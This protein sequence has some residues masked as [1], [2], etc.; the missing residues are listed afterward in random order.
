MSVTLIP[1]NA[2]R[3]KFKVKGAPAGLF[4]DKGELIIRKRI[5]A[6]D[7][8]VYGITMD[9]A[10]RRLPLRQK[11]SKKQRLATRRLAREGG[12]L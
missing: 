1:T 11:R 9:G 5:A 8:T 4:N 7:K 10:W 2:E 6:S 3:T 12:A